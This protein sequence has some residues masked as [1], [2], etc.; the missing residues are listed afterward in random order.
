MS[1]LYEIDFKGSM[2]SVSMIKKRFKTFKI[3]ATFLEMYSLYLRWFHMA[4]KMF[5]TIF[6]NIIPHRG[7]HQVKKNIFPVAPIA[8]KMYLLKFCIKI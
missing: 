4:F 6:K 2:T 8:F 1:I 3:H 7:N 5:Y